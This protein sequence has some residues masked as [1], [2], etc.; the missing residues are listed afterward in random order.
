LKRTVELEKEPEKVKGILHSLTNE[1]HFSKT[2]EGTIRNGV[3]EGYYT[4]L[5]LIHGIVVGYVKIKGTYDRKR[6]DL[7]LT[8]FPGNLYWIVIAFIAVALSILTYKG[9]TED[10][11]ILI[12]SFLLLFMALA[13]TFAFFLESRSF[14]QRIA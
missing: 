3:L 8:I 12:G 9:I 1:H 11:T 6:G 13:I 5:A 7:T 14:I 10:K 4:N 2:F